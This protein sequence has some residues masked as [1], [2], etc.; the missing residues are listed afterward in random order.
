MTDAPFVTVPTAL[1]G[2]TVHTVDNTTAD[3]T[4]ADNTSDD[5]NTV[6]NNT[7]DSTTGNTN[8]KTADINTDDNTTGNQTHP[9][10]VTLDKVRET[11]AAGLRPDAARMR[12]QPYRIVTNMYLLN[13]L[14]WC[15]GGVLICKRFAQPSPSDSESDN[16]PL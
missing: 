6:D 3:N 4:T 9:S 8:N 15:I 5:D 11:S 10:A 2:I 14:V 1:L 16:S 12:A 7:E 13:L